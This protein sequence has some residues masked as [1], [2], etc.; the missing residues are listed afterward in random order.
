[1]AIHYYKINGKERE[2]DALY[3]T[4]QGIDGR[5]EITHTKSIP[6]KGV[7]KE[8]LIARMRKYSPNALI[9]SDD[10]NLYVQTKPTRYGTNFASLIKSRPNEPISVEFDGDTLLITRSGYTSIDFSAVISKNFDLHVTH[11]YLNPTNSEYSVSSYTQGTA[12]QTRIL[13][14]HKSAEYM[15]AWFEE[16]DFPN[17]PEIYE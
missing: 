12:Y 2:R 6:L 11:Y 1:M 16:H 5:H 4:L 3:E 17:K 15:R 10:V 9:Y 13:N 7:V 8:D 14:T